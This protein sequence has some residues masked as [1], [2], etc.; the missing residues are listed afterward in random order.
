MSVDTLRVR[1][2][3]AVAQSHL[4]DPLVLQKVEQLMVAVMMAHSED[5]KSFEDEL[6]WIDNIG[7]ED[8]EEDED[9]EDVESFEDELALLDRTFNEEDEKDDDRD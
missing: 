5:V 1:S 9:C 8:D 4:D 3:L 6:G 7:K 2:C